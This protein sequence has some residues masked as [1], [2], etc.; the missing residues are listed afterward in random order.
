MPVLIAR[1]A[2]VRRRRRR[3]QDPWLFR[4]LDVTVEPGDL[5]AVVGP[6]GSG[7]TTVL[8]AL[9]RRFRLASGR[10]TLEGR[11][12]LG[13]VP[14]VSTPEPV[15][16]VTEHIRERLALL[17]RPCSE[18]ATVPL[19]G[20]EGD[21]QGQELSPYEKQLLGLVLAELADPAVIALDG[22]DDGLNAREQESLLRLITEVAA[23]G[24]AV[25]VTARE[26]SPAD[27]TT[28]I[29]LGADAAQP[30]GASPASG[31][32]D[33]GDAGDTDADMGA[34]VGDAGGAGGSRD[35][36]DVDGAPGSRDGGGTGGSRGAGA[37]VGDP[38]DPGGAEDDRDA[39]GVGDERAAELDDDETGK[40]A[41]R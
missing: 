10:V 27:F 21:K 40:G 37:D 25:I 36:G 16:T 2:G 14:E 41:E 39:G 20:L 24:V 32:R 35:G 5:V 7:R 18:A 31:S 9:A 29:H 15:F 23:R 6:P 1:G 12:S 33:S 19:R 26:A 3:G 28:V 17:G 8:L 22:F 34:D 30:V 4:D 13:Y 11:A 38:G